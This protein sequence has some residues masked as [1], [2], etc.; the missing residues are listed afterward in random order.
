M[1]KNQNDRVETP[2]A[3]PNQPWD[4]VCTCLILVLI[5]KVKKK[6]N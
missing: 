3:F 4:V 6:V 1:K 2:I 5:I